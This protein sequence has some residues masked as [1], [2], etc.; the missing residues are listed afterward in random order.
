MENSRFESGGDCA[1]P[2]HGLSLLVFRR[3]YAYGPG[4]RIRVDGNECMATSWPIPRQDG[5]VGLMVR[6]PEA[7][8][9]LEILLDEHHVEILS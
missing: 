5:R 3:K 6:S 9:S 8:E 2:F 1:G 4:L 7:L